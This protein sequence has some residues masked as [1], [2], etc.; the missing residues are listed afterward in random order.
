LT[1]TDLP[2]LRLSSLEPWDLQPDFFKLWQNQRLLPHLHLPLQS[3][4]DAVLRRMAR[5]TT[6]AQYSQLV[7]AART[8]IPDVSITTDIIVGF[9]GETEAEF[10]ESLA[11]VAEIAFA[12]LHIFRYSRREGTAAATMKD[13]IPSPVVQNRSRQM[14]TLNEKL[15][16]D[17]RQ[18]FVGR[19]MP[20]LW[21]SSEP[22]GL[23]LQWSG[24][25]G[26]YLRVI[27]QTGSGVDLRNR[28][29]ETNL[30]G[31]APAALQGQCCESANLRFSESTAIMH[32]LTDSPPR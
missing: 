10:A 23:G 30:V 4:S 29:V 28:V 6:Q 12:K 26:N 32:S 19:T 20:V 22:Y 16:Q 13:Q 25:T 8:A 5:K 9:P 24:L 2:R 15:E 7:R 27:T 3:G 1:E 18:K 21:E 14:H 31:L 17:F 11:F